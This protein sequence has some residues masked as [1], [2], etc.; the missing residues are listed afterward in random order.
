MYIEITATYD[1]YIHTC[2]EH[3]NMHAYIHTCIYTFINTVDYTY[4]HTYINTYILTYILHT[5]IH[6]FHLTHG[7][8]ALSSQSHRL[9]L[10]LLIKK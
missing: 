4:I 2:T 9:L 7:V 8:N 5:Y 3:T 1:L 6:G 10:K